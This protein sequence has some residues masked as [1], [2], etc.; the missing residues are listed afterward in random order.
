VPIGWLRHQLQKRYQDHL[1]ER[2]EDLRTLDTS[3]EVGE[4]QR[5]IHKYRIEYIVVGGLERHHLTNECLATENSA[6][7]EA[8]V[9]LV[10]Q[11]LEVAFTAGQTVVYRVL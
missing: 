9:L 7:L 3:E 8:F 10:G 4:K 1:V 6:G 11:A 5:I 2:R